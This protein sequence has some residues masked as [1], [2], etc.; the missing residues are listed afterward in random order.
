MIEGSPTTHNFILESPNASTSSIASSWVKSL[1]RST[2][3]VGNTELFYASYYSSDS[4]Y[5]ENAD[6]PIE[7]KT[8]IRDNIQ[9]LS[10]IGGPN[11]QDFVKRVMSKVLSNELASQYSW[12]GLKKKKIFSKLLLCQVII[13][14]FEL[15]VAFINLDAT[16]IHKECNKTCIKMLKKKQQKSTL[17]P[18]LYQPHWGDIVTSSL[19]RSLPSVFA[20]DELSIWS[21][22]EEYFVEGNKEEEEPEK[23]IDKEINVNNVNIRTD[24]KKDNSI[25]ENCTKEEMSDKDKY[26]IRNNGYE[27]IYDEKRV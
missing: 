22:Y 12:L 18:L 9:E 21:N 13:R 6:T 16:F 2:S 5:E 1:P 24:K 25:A 19:T 17:Q 8:Q 20:D 10:R 7:R 26:S 15:L 11:G 27:K 4:H 3:C 23:N 14:K